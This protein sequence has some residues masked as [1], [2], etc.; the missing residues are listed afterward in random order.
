MA[1]MQRAGRV[2]GNELDIDLFAVADP[3]IAIGST[4]CQ[5]IAEA[6]PP[7]RRVKPQI[8]EAGSGDLG[9]RHTVRRFQPGRDQR[10]QVAR[11]HPRRLGQHHGRIARQVAVAGIA[12][13]IDRHARQIKTGRQRRL[14]DKTV[15]RRDNFIPVLAKYIHG[16]ATIFPVRRWCSRSA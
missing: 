13:R 12:R 2:G 1:D 9:R 16:A 3:G 11:P 4:L 5:N 7:D 6:A 8:D 15:Y 10:R 14:R